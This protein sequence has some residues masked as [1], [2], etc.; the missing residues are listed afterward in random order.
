MLPS[1]FRA[2]LPSVLLLLAFLAIIPALIQAFQLAEKGFVYCPAYPCVCESEGEGGGLAVNCQY[3]YLTQLPKFLAFDGRIRTLSLRQNSIRQLPA[4]GFH[5]LRV[6]SL[7]LTEN[8]ISHVDDDAFEGL[9]DSLE[10]LQLQVS[11]K[12]MVMPKKCINV[13]HVLT[14]CIP[15]TERASGAMVARLS[16]VQEARVRAPSGTRILKL[17]ITWGWMR[18]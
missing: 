16:P 9:E 18:R 11:S 4:R 1:D 5:G 12:H 10:E 8:V 2:P 13:T 6:Q 17:P 14:L 15:P 7:D 3:L